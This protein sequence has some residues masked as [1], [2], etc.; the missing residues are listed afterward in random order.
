MGLVSSIFC[1]LSGS[2][3]GRAGARQ[4]PSSVVPSQIGQPH[5]PG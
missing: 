1:T 3:G 5:L 2:W 4:D